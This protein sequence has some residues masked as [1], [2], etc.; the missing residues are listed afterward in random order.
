MLV[1]D[2]P[3]RSCARD[4]PYDHTA[5]DKMHGAKAWMIGGFLKPIV[6]D[7]LFFLLLH[8]PFGYCIN[9]FQKEKFYG[10]K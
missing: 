5:T 6:I 9:F 3:I 4:K 1:F 8:S 7:G 10:H 2:Q